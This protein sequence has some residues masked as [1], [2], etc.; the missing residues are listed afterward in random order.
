MTR[1]TAALGAVRRTDEKWPFSFEMARRAMG[2]FASQCPTVAGSVIAILADAFLLATTNSRVKLVSMK[3]GT[4]VS[5]QEYLSTIYE[6]DC[7]YVDGEI[8]ER[9]MGEVD[10]GGLQLAIGAWMYSRRKRLGIH[11]FTETRTQV[12]ARRY[13]VPDIAVTID[14]PKERILREPPFLCI[15][16]V[17]PEDRVGR[18]E[19]KIDDYLKF[20]VQYVW[21]IDA[22][23]K[24]AWSYTQTGKRQAVSILVTEKPRIELPI[25]DLFAELG[26]EIEAG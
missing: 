24:S 8:L 26:E 21:L 2:G 18:M 5:E 19:E 13:R 4:L 3:S 9:N 11:V 12:A 10:H 20:G 23:K 25:L 6:P 1:R 16:I 22:R 14:K 7:E 15:E 17:S